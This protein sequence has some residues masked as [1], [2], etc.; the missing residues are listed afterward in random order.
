MKNVELK[1]G[2]NV[3]CLY[4]EDISPIT[5]GTPGVVKSVSE[6]Y[7]QKQYYVEWRNG[8]KLALLEGEWVDC[9]PE[10]AKTQKGKNRDVRQK[11]DG[12]W[13]YKN[14]DSWLKTGSTKEDMNENFMFFTTKRAL[15]NETKQNKK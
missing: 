3:V 12:S 2:D 13:Q 11:E 7:G 5:T 8:S 6:V 1:P 4:M 9:S 10:E 14:G 15:I